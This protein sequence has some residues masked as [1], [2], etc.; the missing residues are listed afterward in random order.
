[1]RFDAKNSVVTGAAL[2]SF[3]AIAG[4]FVLA[5]IVVATTTWPAHVAT[6]AVMNS[7]LRAAGG[8]AVATLAT[9]D[10]TCIAAGSLVR[11][12]VVGWPAALGGCLFGIYFGDLGLWFTGR[13]AAKVPAVNRWMQRRVSAERRAAF[14]DWFERRAPVAI[15]V[16]RFVPGMRLPLYLAAGATRRG[17]CRF[18]WW[19]FLAALVWTPLLVGGVALLGDAVAMPLR[20]VFNANWIIVPGTI[21]AAWIV[22]RWTAR[23]TRKSRAARLTA[24]VSRL[25]RW[26]FWPAWIFYAPAAVWI[27]AKSLR[28]GGLSGFARITAANPGIPDGGFVG[29]SKRQILSALPR[30]CI[31]PFAHLPPGEK[32]ERI[33]AFSATI[34]AAGWRF[35]LILKPDVGQRGAGVRL[36][37]SMDDVR[38]YLDRHPEDLLVQPYHAGPFEVGVFYYRIPGESRGRVFSITEKVFPVVIGD[39]ES[40]LAELVWSHPRYCMQADRFLERHAVRA[41]EVIPAGDRVSLAVAGNH[42]QGTLFRDGGHLC[43]RDL[44][45][46]IDCIAQAY[47]GFYFGR[48]DIRFSDVA[49]FRR[50]EDLAIV[51]LNGVTSESTDIYDPRRSLWSAWAKLIRQWNLLFAIA[52]ANVVRGHEPTEWRCLWASIRQHWRQPPVEAAAD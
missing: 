39:G 38:R 4:L 19:S 25:W 15:F 46:A 48:F 36:A 12:N 14:A 35:P 29:E 3:H 43:T 10:L 52:D 2:P 20:Q 13:L 5:L 44:E 31:I 17:G 34:D 21:A 47:D 40:T 1:M 32:E 8:L 11:L 22:L 37:R 42:C 16:A 28:R 50:G 51:E 7:E 49:T 33:A 23:P 45:S 6:V 18:A 26:E 30:E 24:C 41:E 9:E 27:V